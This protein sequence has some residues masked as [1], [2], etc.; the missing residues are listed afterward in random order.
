MSDHHSATKQVSTSQ[1]NLSAADNMAEYL[2]AQLEEAAFG[3][4]NGHISAPSSRATFTFDGGNDTEGEEEVDGHAAVSSEPKVTIKTSPKKRAVTPAGE[5]DTSP[6][7]KRIP[8]KGQAVI[9]RN[10]GTSTTNKKGR[11]AKPKLE[12]STKSSESDG[13]VN[14]NDIERPTTPE[15]QAVKEPKTPKTPK[16]PTDDLYVQANE[17]TPRSAKVKTQPKAKATPKISPVKARRAGAEKVAE[18]VVLPA[19]WS[20]ATPADRNLVAM[21]EAGKSWNEIRVEWYKMTGQ[22]TAASTLPNR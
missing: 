11:Q 2:R 13:A 3:L 10:G 17:K 9:E 15:P 18:K 6:K 8:A 1:K 20:E 12:E 22:E 5:E 19:K 14:G 4:H 7:K 16:S 21:K